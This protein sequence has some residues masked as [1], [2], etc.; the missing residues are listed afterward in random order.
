MEAGDFIAILPLLVLAGAAVVVML[1]VAVR[2]SH[3][4]SFALSL[5]GLAAAF[6]SLWP[7]ASAAPR[8]VTTLLT[9]DS[10]AI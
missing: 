7:A 5:A 8:Q 2:R 9:I 10:Y 4:A 6:A 3:A 1:G